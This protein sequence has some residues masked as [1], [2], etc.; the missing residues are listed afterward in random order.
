[1]HA[2]CTHTVMI[3]H[4][5]TSF[6]IHDPCSC[7]CHPVASGRACCYV[8]RKALACAASLDKPASSCAAV[9]CVEIAF[10]ELRTQ[11][12]IRASY[13]S[14]IKSYTNARQSRCEEQS[15]GSVS[16]M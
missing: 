14:G 12:V 11:K 6:Y 13:D 2:A 3:K 1:M 4:I 10:E 7:V 16:L 15:E 8:H 5:H 9:K